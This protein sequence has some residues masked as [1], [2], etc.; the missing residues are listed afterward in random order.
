[1]IKEV[2]AKNIRKLRNL[3]N[4][5]VQDLAAKVG[6]NRSVISK[7]ES[8]AIMPECSNLEHLQK[9][10]EIDSPLAFFENPDEDMTRV[11]RQELERLKQVEKEAQ[12]IRGWLQGS[13][14]T[15]LQSRH[16]WSDPAM[17]IV[18]ISGDAMATDY[19]QANPIFDVLALTPAL[20]AR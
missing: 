17:D 1:M 20:I 12:A 11:S 8:A 10:F 7:W 18:A 6:V 4:W 14:L 19:Q 5:S 15:H 13:P 3:R 2:V 9:I 16:P